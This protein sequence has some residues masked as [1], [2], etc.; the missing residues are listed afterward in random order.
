M[1]EADQTNILPVKHTTY[2][3]QRLQEQRTNGM[4]CD[5]TLIVEGE[6]FR[7][8]KSFLAAN[9][10]YFLSLFTSA[11]EQQN[12]VLAG[13]PLQGFRVL[14]DF[15]YTS[16]FVLNFSNVHDVYK[17]SSVLDF[18]HVKA[19]CE[20]VYRKIKH[21]VDS[22]NLEYHTNRRERYRP[23]PDTT[24]RDHAVFGAL[25]SKSSPNSRG[26]PP[27][28]HMEMEKRPDMP[29]SFMQGRPTA[30]DIRLSPHEAEMPP[31]IK[32]RQKRKIKTEPS[33]EINLE[34][35]RT[36]KRMKEAASDNSLTES[37]GRFSS[38]VSFEDDTSSSPTAAEIKY[39]VETTESERNNASSLNLRVPADSES[40]DPEVH[41][42]DW[43]AKARNTKQV[44]EERV[45]SPVGFSSNLQPWKVLCTEK[46]ERPRAQRNRRKTSKTTR[47]SF[48]SDPD[49]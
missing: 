19:A 49:S 38:P 47:I 24:D 12:F 15:V 3:L 48:D 9:S 20:K 28:M 22:G 10:D 46:S 11:Q 29:L 33:H 4:F 14:M 2:V 39:V 26:S 25:N 23:P 32:P 34:L 8:H 31:F 21:N 35:E 30:L 37:N 40:S 36:T 42:P 5:A 13:V 44:A 17:A 45:N 27:I 41:D 7:V 18:H 6:K 43:P 16:T 1:T